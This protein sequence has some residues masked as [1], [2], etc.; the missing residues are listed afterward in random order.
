M[1]PE[2]IDTT[3]EENQSEAC[4]KMIQE[5]DYLKVQVQKVQ[6]YYESKIEMLQRD[7]EKS[8]KV[9]YESGK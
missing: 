2:R 7:I 4:S 9:I 6:D 5:N 8:N 3:T 1:N